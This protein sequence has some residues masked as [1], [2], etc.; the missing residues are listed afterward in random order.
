MAHRSGADFIKLFPITNSGVDYV[1]AVRTPL[2]HIKSLAV[3]GVDCNNMPEY[4]KIGICGFGIGS[5]IT[6]KKPIESGDFKAITRLA[7]NL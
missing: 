6:D 4:L 2:S 7:E 5:S 1:K 3:G